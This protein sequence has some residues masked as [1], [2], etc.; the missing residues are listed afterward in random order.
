VATPVDFFTSRQLRTI[1]QN[2]L[3]IAEIPG[4]ENVYRAKPR[5]IDWGDTGDNGNSMFAYPIIDDDEHRIA[6]GGPFSG[7]KEYNAT[8]RLILIFR[9]WEADWELAQDGYDD[10]KDRI[11]WQLRSQGRTLGQPAL[12]LQIG[13]GPVGIRHTQT[14]PMM[15]DGGNIE[16]LGELTFEVT[17]VITT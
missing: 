15:L 7:Q 17:S 10:L 6:M 8:V 5:E 12:I 13:E 14:E 11:R 1:L 3:N 9:S 2:F 16:I 4:L